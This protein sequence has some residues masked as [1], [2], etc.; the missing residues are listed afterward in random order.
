MRDRV[1][2]LPARYSRGR[3]TQCLGDSYR[4]AKVNDEL[5]DALH[6]TF[7]TETVMQLQALI[8][9]PVM[10]CG[11]RVSQ[12]RRMLTADDIREELIR[13]VQ[14]FERSS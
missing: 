6:E 8:T 3:N 5:R 10:G 1:R 12:Y 13:A 9:K 11:L 4:A 7:V 2:G 14:D